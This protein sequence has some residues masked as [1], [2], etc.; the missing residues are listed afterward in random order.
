MTIGKKVA[1]WCGIAIVRWAVYVAVCAALHALLQPVYNRHCQR[2]VIHIM[3]FKQSGLCT[4]LKR[5]LSHVEDVFDPS[6]LVIAGSH[7]GKIM[8]PMQHG[9]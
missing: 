9:Q 4:T 2:T 6:V 1:Y 7:L 5:V 8:S 3:M